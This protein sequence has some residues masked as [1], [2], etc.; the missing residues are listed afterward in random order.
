MRFILKFIIFSYAL[1]AAPGYAA[2]PL[3]TVTSKML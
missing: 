1:I 2:S 3:D